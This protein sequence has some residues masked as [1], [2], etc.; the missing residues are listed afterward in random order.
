MLILRLV[1]VDV[2]SRL[3]HV[4]VRVIHCLRGGDA[5]GGVEAQQTHEQVQS[6]WTRRRKHRPQ[7]LLK[8]E[9]KIVIITLEEK[10]L[11]NNDGY[12]TKQYKE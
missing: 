5:L 4:E 12:N 1:G 10:V 11:K 9:E 3:E 8:R 6:E 7:I 2:V